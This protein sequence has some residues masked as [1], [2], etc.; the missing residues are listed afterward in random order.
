MLCVY[1]WSWAYG[2]AHAGTTG[3]DII[4]GAWYVGCSWLRCGLTR[5]MLLVRARVSS[6]LNN[7]NRQISNW[8]LLASSTRLD[9]FFSLHGVWE[10][11]WRLLLQELFSFP[12]GYKQGRQGMA[13][14]VPCFCREY[15]L[16]ITGHLS[17]MAAECRPAVL[18]EK[19]STQMTQRIGLISL[20]PIFSTFPPSWLLNA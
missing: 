2:G 15:P 5:G 7:N 17:A 12:D 16:W 9:G 13:L 14:A 19:Q 6:R 10:I 1:T 3:F 20:Q 11:S 4:F 18:A 8:M